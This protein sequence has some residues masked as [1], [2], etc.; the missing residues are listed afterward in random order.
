MCPSSPS[1]CRLAQLAPTLLP[2]SACRS[3]I[4]APL[5]APRTHSPHPLLLTRSARRLGDLATNKKDYPTFL[6]AIAGHEATFVPAFMSIFKHFDW[7][8]I[9]VVSEKSAVPR[10]I[11]D[12]LS[13]DAQLKGVDL[14]VEARKVY[15][16]T[17]CAQ[18]CSPQYTRTA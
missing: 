12:A 10:G 17:L 14:A 11:H 4:L 3:S 2:H 9:G 6:R 5:A 18:S 1:F 15:D 13:V 7:K 8:R 16:C